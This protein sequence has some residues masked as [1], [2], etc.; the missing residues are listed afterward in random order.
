MIFVVE[1]FEEAKQ[2]RQFRFRDIVNPDSNQKVWRLEHEVRSTYH[3][4]Y[5]RP[6]VNRFGNAGIVLSMPQ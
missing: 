3:P 5:M 2:S 1:S 4:Y 6:L